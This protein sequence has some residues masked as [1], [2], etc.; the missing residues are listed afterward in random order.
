[1]KFKD[2]DLSSEFD[3]ITSRSSGSGGQNVN[4]VSTKVEL[5]FQVANSALLDDDEKVLIQQKIALKINQEGFLRVVVQETRSQLQNKEI[6]VKKFYEILEKA[7]I[8]PKPRKK[9]KPSK[10]AIEERLTEKK[11]NAA[12]KADRQ[13]NH[14]D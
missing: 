9:A 13:Q 10:K 3:F 12:K 8:V 7:F 1:M 14:F 11:K 6:A 4:K 5:R 2:R